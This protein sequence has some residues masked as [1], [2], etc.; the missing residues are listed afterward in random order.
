MLAVTAVLALTV[1]LPASANS[2]PTT[3]ARINI[4]SPPATYPADTAFYVEQGFACYLNGNAPDCAN[5][6]TSF[7][8]Y[9]DGVQQAS[10]KDVDTELLDSVTVLHVE[11]LTNFAQGFTPGTHT[12]TGVW[13]LNGSFFDAHIASVTFT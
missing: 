11:Y 13:Y 5:A 10:Q 8:L 12:F 4:L 9:V 3:G 1:V 2:V 6:N 7:V